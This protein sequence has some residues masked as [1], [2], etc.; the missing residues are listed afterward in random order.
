MEKRSM[1]SNEF[2]TPEDMVE[3]VKI[4]YLIKW[5]GYP[6]SDNQW[7]DW[8]DLHAEEALEDFR[9]RQPCYVRA[10]RSTRLEWEGYDQ[11]S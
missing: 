10:E 4:K 6:D 1:K 7:V 9:R 8:N 3:G 2:W 11:V 5:K